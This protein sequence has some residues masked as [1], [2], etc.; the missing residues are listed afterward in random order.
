MKMRM[1]ITVAILVVCNSMLTVQA[2][3]W[4][5][6]RG[7]DRTAVA[8]DSELM[9]V[10]PENGP[11]LLWKSSGIGNG[12]SSLAIVE[13]QIFTMGDHLPD[14]DGDEYLICL[15]RTNGEIVW[16][17]KTGEPFQQR[18][19]K[20][21][22]PRSTPTVDDDRVY[23]LSPAG[24]MV[25]AS[26]AGEQLWEKNLPDDFQGKKA[27]GWGYSESVLIDGDK[28]IC[29]P[30]GPANTMTALDKLTGETIWTTSRGGDR[31]AGHASTVISQVGDTKIYVTSTGSGPI[32]VRASDGK[33]LWTYDI[34]RTTAVI[35]TPI[36]R[37]DLVFFTAGYDKG[38]ALLR[39]SPGENGQVTIEEIYPINSEL[40]SKHGGVVLLGDYLYA[41]RDSSP[42]IFCAELMTGDIAWESRGA[43]SG[44]ASVVAADGHIYFRFESGEMMLVEAN[45]K[46]VVEKGHFVVP[47]SG[48]RPSWSHPVI[49]EG[50]LY[51]RE[52]NDLLCYQLRE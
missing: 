44:S 31:G 21:E 4:P 47:G 9:S 20:W 32:G 28:L 12:Y 24:R 34:S 50:M 42:I 7:P 30:G 25:C 6:F 19:E 45:P 13:D 5:T 22:S 2:E 16:K 51:L 38:G 23:V 46:R 1:N 8:P 26:T 11:Q 29:T 52:G 10:W 17:L 27:D 18:N 15:S 3:T 33:L 39:Q 49:L 36:V 48:S 37:D 14:S 41:G 35:P 40:K 43:G